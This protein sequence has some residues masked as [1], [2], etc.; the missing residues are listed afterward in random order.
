MFDSA[1]LTRGIALYRSLA[2]TNSD[3]TLFVVCLDEDS[4]KLLDAL[5][6]PSIRSIPLAEIEAT[7]PEFYATKQTRGVVDYYFTL[8][9]VL[10]L[11]I[12]RTHPEIDIITCLDADLIFYANP[13]ILYEELGDG[14]VFIVPH[15][16]ADHLKWREQCGLYNVQCQMFR[17]DARGL[18]CLN[19]WR[20][21][22]VEWCRNEL[23]DGKYA[24]QKYLDEFP[25]RFDGV[26]VSQV[27][28]AGLAPWNWMRYDID[29][30]DAG[31]PTVDGEPLVFY[32]F[33]GVKL[34][35]RH[36]VMNNMGY[37]GRV[38]PRKLR[39][40]FY[41]RYVEELRA[42]A[43]WIQQRTG[44][45]ASNSFSSKREGLS[46]LRTYA[47]AMLRNSLMWV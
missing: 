32:H 21:R 45:E 34:L 14:A 36:L 28:G 47:S 31:K 39:Y 2:R 8:S 22:C 33:Q 41:A 27:K 18:A 19:W 1:Y 38:M 6:E 40:W 35:S 5:A 23:V 44:R 11:H 12:L 20:E 29:I 7:D 17:N 26:V 30:A 10:P 16:F 46:R 3:F 13:D 24:D 43:E 9:P 4:L 42:A 25:R 37:Y 15:R